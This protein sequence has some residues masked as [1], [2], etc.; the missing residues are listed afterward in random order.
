MVRARLI[1]VILGLALVLAACGGSAGETTASLT[2]SPGDTAPPVTPQE[3]VGGDP[4]DSDYPVAGS[5]AQA[6]SA[7]STATVTLENGEAFE[8]SIRCELEPQVGGDVEILF[9]LVSYDEP[10]KLNVTQFAA[11]S[12]NGV[13]GI[14]ISDSTTFELVW[15]ATAVL[16]AGEVEL[17]LDGNTVMG[18]GM[19]L[20]GVDSSGP[21]VRGELVA[22]CG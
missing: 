20:E 16:G 2:P 8:F 22:N 17:T 10:L 11:D 19:F 1:P 9:S 7:S 3:E 18:S 13:A 12:F 4:G 5:G 21:G 14:S 15:E 6:P